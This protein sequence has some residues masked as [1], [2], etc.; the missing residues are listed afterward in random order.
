MVQTEKQH[1]NL[2]IIYEEQTP[3]APKKVANNLNFIGNDY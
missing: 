1:D 3:N 2:S